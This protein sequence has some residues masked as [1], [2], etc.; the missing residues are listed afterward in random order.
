M[1]SNFKYKLEISSIDDDDIPL[2]PQKNIKN[3]PKN[4]DTNL[5]KN[6]QVDRMDIKF[7]EEYVK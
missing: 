4:Y 2:F 1:K 6:L 7:R 5:N 3:A